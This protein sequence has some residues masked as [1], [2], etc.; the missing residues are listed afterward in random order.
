MR[1]RNE[2]GERLGPFDATM[3]EVGAY[4]QL[5]ADVHLGPEQAIRAHQ[6]LRGKVL[7]PVHWGTFD[8]GVHG[9]TEPIERIIAAARLFAT[10]GNADPHIGRFSALLCTGWFPGTAHHAAGCRGWASVA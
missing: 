8:L 3:I 7:L 4:N 6:M 2:I 9:W 10:A 1:L 5:W